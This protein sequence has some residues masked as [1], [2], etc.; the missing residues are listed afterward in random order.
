MKST[1]LTLAMIMAV[2][3]LAVAGCGADSE[4]YKGADRSKPCSEQ[5][6]EKSNID[7][8]EYDLGANTGG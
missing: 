3:A 8:C 2:A 6:K 4:T 7:R 5:Y 1:R